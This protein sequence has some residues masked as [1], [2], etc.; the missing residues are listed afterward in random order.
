MPDLSLGEWFF[1]ALGIGGFL[2]LGWCL[3]WLIG[4]EAP[5]PAPLDKALD[6]LVSAVFAAITWARKNAALLL[7][8]TASEALR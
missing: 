1:L 2:R 4:T 3:V 8:A 6:V 5:M 7:P